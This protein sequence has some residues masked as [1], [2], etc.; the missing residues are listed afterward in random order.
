MVRIEGDLWD[1]TE[2][3]LSTGIGMWDTPGHI[4]GKPAVECTREEL[5]QECWAQ[6]SHAKHNLKLPV[7]IPAWDIWRSFQYDTEKHQ[8]DTW[9]PKFSN[10]IN[11]LKFRPDF[12]DKRINNLYHATA[13][14]KTYMNIFNMESAAE[15]GVKAAKLIKGAPIEPHG[16]PGLFIR[17]CR[18]VDRLLFKLRW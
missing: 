16:R 2:D 13:Y 6:I 7:D 8:M 14:T 11:T 9:E 10:N 3:Y 1:T 4:F 5:A 12:A 15:S 18:W 17:I